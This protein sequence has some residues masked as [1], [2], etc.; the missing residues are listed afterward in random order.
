MIGAFQRVRRSN[1]VERR[2]KSQASFGRLADV[3]EPVAQ[4]AEPWN[5]LRV[6]FAVRLLR[7]AH[8]VDH[9]VLRFS[10]AIERSEAASQRL[11]QVLLAQVEHSQLCACDRDRSL[12]ERNR[13]AMMAGSGERSA[14]A[15]QRSEDSLGL[16]SAVLFRR[17]HCLGIGGF[18][19]CVLICVEVRV[20]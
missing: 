9:G 20:S 1:D 7:D 5:D 17:S 19:W 15:R 4:V 18:G 6:A 13:V 3:C 16:A 2:L 10:L 8:P 11:E 12:Q 14:Q